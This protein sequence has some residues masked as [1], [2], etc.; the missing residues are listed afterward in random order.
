MT[1]YAAAEKDDFPDAAA[2]LGL[3]YLYLRASQIGQARDQIK[4]GLTAVPEDAQL[5]NEGMFVALLSRDDT[6]A[7]RRFDDIEQFYPNSGMRFLRDAS[8]TTVHCNPQRL[9]LL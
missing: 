1:E 4:L 2:Y 3:T 6:E 8:I 5:L 9:V 7:K